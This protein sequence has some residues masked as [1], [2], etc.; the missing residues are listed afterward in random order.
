MRHAKKIRETA[1]CKTG[2]LRKDLKE[3]VEKAVTDSVSEVNLKEVKYS[4]RGGNGHIRYML[5][6]LEDY[7]KWYILGAQGV[8]KCKDKTRVFDFSNTTLEHIYPQSVKGADK[9]AALEKIKH[10]IGNLTIFGPNDNEAIA[11]KLYSAKRSVLQTSN[12]KLNRD[13]GENDQWTPAT[14]RERTKPLIIM[15]LR[16][17]VP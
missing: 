9:V 3:L 16:V 5:I 15:A 4:A 1:N 17:F 8:P 14:A 2:E 12:L 6:T 13:I 10:T 11:N 7:G